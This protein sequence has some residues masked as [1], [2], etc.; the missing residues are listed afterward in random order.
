MNQKRALTP[1]STLWLGTIDGL[2]VGLALET[3][4][5]TYL[6]YQ[7]SLAAWEY[8]ETNLW[9][10]FT[11]A[12][13]EPLT[14]LVSMLVFAVVGYLVRRYFMNRPRLLISLWFGIGGIALALG[15]FM[16]TLSP[17]LFSFLGLFGLAAVIYLAHRLWKA[18]PD[19]QCLFW[20]I[21]GVSVVVVVALGVQSAGLFFYWR[22]LRRPLTWLIFLA[23]VVAINAAFGC[24]VE[25]ILNR[26]NSRKFKEASAQ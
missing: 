22:D 1:A 5:V 10:D 17:D 12:R 4:R 9:A 16:S 3:G 14:P 13:W 6:N 19:S 7:M 25:L 2:L 11:S 23:G 24:V 20:A 8:A 26:F 18:H 21:N 15:F